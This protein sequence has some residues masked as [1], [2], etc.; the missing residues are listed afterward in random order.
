MGN[1][2][3]TTQASAPA[4]GLATTYNAL[5]ERVGK[6]LGYTRTSGNW[7]TEER[8]RVDEAIAD[9]LR[10]FYLERDW[11]FLK[12]W[13]TFNTVADDD[14]YDLDEAVGSIVS[15]IFY[16]PAS[17]Y[18]KIRLIGI[19]QLIE[20]QQ[21]TETS[22]VP[23]YAAVRPKTSTGTT[24]QVKELLL[25]PTPGEVWTLTYQYRVVPDL[26]ETDRQ[27]ALGAPMHAQTILEACLAAAE[28]NEDD[29]LAVHEAAYQRLLARSIEY[30]ALQYAPRT[31]GY[32]GNARPY[33]PRLKPDIVLEME[34]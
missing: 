31:L 6:H 30:D 19:D 21:V 8:D 9:G 29:T 33:R 24:V 18:H 7:A 10:R 27:Y 28:L 23:M 25:W 11:S 34:E 26:L 22:G 15:D 12:P 2:F 32:N 5:L 16:E 3:T 4:A 20:R 13:T 1:A 17:N 14:D